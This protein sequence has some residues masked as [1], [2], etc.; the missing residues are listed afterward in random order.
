MTSQVLLQPSLPSFHGLFPATLHLKCI[1]ASQSSISGT[2]HHMLIGKYKK[3]L[4]PLRCLLKDTFQIS[5]PALDSREVTSHPPKRTEKNCALF[6]KKSCFVFTFFKLKSDAQYE[7]ISSWFECLN[8][9]WPA[10]K[11]ISSYCE[12]F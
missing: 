7:F 2:C 5:Y 11:V 3:D 12:L 8:N 1:S 9:V 4:H 10:V 6:S